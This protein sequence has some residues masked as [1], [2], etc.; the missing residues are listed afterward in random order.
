M[1]ASIKERSDF[2]QRKWQKFIT[3][4]FIQIDQIMQISIHLQSLLRF[5][6]LL[7]STLKNIQTLSALIRVEQTAIL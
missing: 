2:F 7:R 5:R 3:A 1:L 4:E 6:A